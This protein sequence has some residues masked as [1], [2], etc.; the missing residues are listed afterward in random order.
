MLL[1]VLSKQEKKSKFINKYIIIYS[2]VNIILFSVEYSLINAI[3][4][5]AK[6]MFYI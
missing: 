4:S 6:N 5:G 3:C 2:G 1:Y